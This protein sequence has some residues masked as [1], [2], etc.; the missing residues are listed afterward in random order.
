MDGAG[1]D[2]T[3]SDPYGKAKIN[4]KEG[5]TLIEINHS[6]KEKWQ[7]V[8]SNH[9]TNK[10]IDVTLNDTTIPQQTEPKI[11]YIEKEVPAP[12]TINNVK[13]DVGAVIVLE[14]IYYDY[15]SSMKE[16]NIL[17]DLMLKNQRLKIKLTA[18]TDSR[19]DADYNQELSQKRAD[20]AKNYLISRGID[21]QNITSVG[22]GET[23]LRNH[24]KDGVYC[25]EAE[26]IYN[27]RTEVVIIDN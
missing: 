20:S 23:Q 7:L 9:G 17:A 8:M 24:C 1:I 13:V 10:N 16:L 26:H 18:H 25:T 27:R 15:N 12:V 3:Y 2:S 4:L 6:G 11:I 21:Y 5:H 14:N 19:G 22:Y